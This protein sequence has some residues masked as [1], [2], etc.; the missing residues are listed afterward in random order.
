M[1]YYTAGS[2]LKNSL[3]SLLPLISI[4]VPLAEDTISTILM[5]SVLL[6]HFI[7]LFVRRWEPKR[8]PVEGSS[9]RDLASNELYFA[10]RRGRRAAIAD[11]PRRG[12]RVGISSLTDKVRR[13]ASVLPSARTQNSVTRRRRRGAIDARPA[14]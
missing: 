5:A 1:L 13:I 4:I 12:R 7:D 6:P 3:I 2:S 14:R 10:R 9:R 11:P 8:L